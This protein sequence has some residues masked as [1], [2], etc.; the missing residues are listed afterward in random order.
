M[1][2]NEQE[3]IINK[4]TD[5]IIKRGWLSNKDCETLKINKIL[6]RTRLHVMIIDWFLD[7]LSNPNTLIPQSLKDSI[8]NATDYTLNGYDEGIITTILC[9]SYDIPDNTLTELIILLIKKNAMASPDIQEVLKRDY[10]I[11]YNKVK[12]Q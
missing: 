10:N 4:F 11:D 3:Q 8:D 7:V 12:S 5:S 6:T 1:N 9:V 2:T